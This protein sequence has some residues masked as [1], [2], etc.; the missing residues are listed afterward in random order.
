MQD[1]TISGT[2]DFKMLEVLEDGITRGQDI[3]SKFPLGAV[4]CM[5]VLAF[6]NINGSLFCGYTLL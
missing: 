3:L 6:L 4:Q 1:L 5:L 2:S